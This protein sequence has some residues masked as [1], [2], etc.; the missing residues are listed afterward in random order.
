MAPVQ[1][2]ISTAALQSLPV[3]EVRNVSAHLRVHDITQSSGRVQQGL[4]GTHGPSESITARRS[5]RKQTLACQML[6]PIRARPGIY[7][8]AVRINAPSLRAEGGGSMIKLGVI[9]S[10]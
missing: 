3:A 8:K 7:Q 9:D 5:L 1:V 10:N 4:L 6:L 2:D